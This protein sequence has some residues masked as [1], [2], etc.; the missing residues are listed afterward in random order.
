VRKGQRVVFSVDAFPADTFAGTV[1]EIRLR[2]AVSSNV[3]TY[4]TIIDAPN[5]DL[6]LKPGMTASIIIYTR[7]VNNVLLIPSAA[8]VFTPDSVLKEKFNL[9]NVDNA[10]KRNSNRQGG[11]KAPSITDSSGNKI[12]KGRVWVKKDSVTIIRVPVTTGLDDKSIVQVVTGLQP[13][14]E[15]ITGYKKLSKQAAAATTNKSPFMPTRGG[16]GRR[17]N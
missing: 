16:G 7:E 8:L 9:T 17:P 11:N 6:K 15:V 5:A 10:A 4:T 2:A 13:G 3:V 12:T 14:D 1:K